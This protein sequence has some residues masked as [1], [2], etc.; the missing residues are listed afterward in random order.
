MIDPALHSLNL[1]ERQRAMLAAMGIRQWWP[2][3]AAQ[4][5]AAPASAPPTHPAHPTAHAP[6]A[7]PAP[8]AAP[9]ARPPVQAPPTGVRSPA[10]NTP[11]TIAA[12]TFK[13]S[14]TG[15]FDAQNSPHADCGWD[16]LTERI[17]SCQACGLCQG[18]QQAVPGMGNRQARWMIVGEAPGEQ[19]DHQG[20]PFVGPAGQLLDAM[21]AAMGLQRE[22]DVYIANV[23][24]CRP[25]HN[26]N[27]EPE[28]VARCQPFLQRQI[29]LVQPDLLLAVGRFAA[30]TLLQGVV[31]DVEKLPLGRLRGRVHTVNQRPVVVTYHPAY[32][33]R[34]PAEKGKVWADLCLAMERLGHNPLST[35]QP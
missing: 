3:P 10:S 32:L 14:A 6:A 35:I 22:A 9:P 12:H 29:E 8:V 24:K 20:L 18:R 2:D 15:P 26:R 34:S 17:R 27:P 21:L 4:P 13:E 11:E 33:L 23:I 30:Q 28:E 25:P 16:E 31:P 1:D 7:S 19:E 5:Q